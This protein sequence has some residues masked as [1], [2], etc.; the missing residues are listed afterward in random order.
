MVIQF[1]ISNKGVYTLL[2]LAVLL[3][4]FT[5]V[6]AYNAGFSGGDASVMG[7]SADELNVMVGTT[8]KSLQSAINDGDFGDTKIM[9]RSY[10]NYS[11]WNNPS[12]YE[13]RECNKISFELLTSTAEGGSWGMSNCGRPNHRFMDQDINRL[14]CMVIVAEIGAE[15]CRHVCLRCDEW[16]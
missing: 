16:A 12:G 1:S 6:Y 15:G 7:H 13:D 8:E 10:T 11:A 3:I 2:T 5:N 14:A 4:G 9:G